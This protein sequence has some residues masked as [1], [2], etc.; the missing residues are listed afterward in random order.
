MWVLIA[1]IFVAILV[2]LYI[3]SSFQTKTTQQGIVQSVDE[4][5]VTAAMG[6]QL[7]PLCAQQRPGTYAQ[8]QIG[9]S[10]FP[11]T[12]PTGAA[13][14]CQVTASGSANGN[15]VVL[16]LDGPPK[17]WALAGINAKQGSA[18][19]T[20]QMNF[21]STVAADM[22]QALSG[23]NDVQVGVIQANDPEPFL[24]VSY[25]TPQ[26]VELCVDK[27]NNQKYTT[28]ALALGVAKKVF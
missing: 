1:A 23:Q 6:V 22:A 10:G 17:Q 26:Q 16:Y 27:P 24:N 3:L 14:M 7:L 19:A 21:A 8:S 4:A 12:T 9:A 5:R 18:S 20:I 28:P 11:A 2:A 13:W 15:T 25:P